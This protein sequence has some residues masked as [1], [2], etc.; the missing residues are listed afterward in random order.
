[1]ITHNDTP[2]GPLISKF[3]ENDMLPARYKIQPAAENVTV[4]LFIHFM[5]KLPKNVK[6]KQEILIV[7]CLFT[8]FNK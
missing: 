8:L 4:D 3:G 7:T 1:M 6:K 5:I 2:R